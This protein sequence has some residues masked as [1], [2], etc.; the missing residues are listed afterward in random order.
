MHIGGRVVAQLLGGVAGQFGRPVQCPQP[1]GECG[2]F[3]QLGLGGVPRRTRVIAA[4]V[5]DAV[6]MVRRLGESGPGVGEMHRPVAAG[7]ARRARM[8]VPARLEIGD[9][10]QHALR[11]SVLG[12]GGG[13]VA[14]QRA[15]RELFGG[16]G[17][18]G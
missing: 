4:R 7:D 18:T 15:G 10:E 14:L 12:R 3:G 2:R 1:S 5:L 13:E 16:G 11:Y 9:A 6:R 17:R 8:S